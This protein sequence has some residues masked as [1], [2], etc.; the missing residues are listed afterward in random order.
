MYEIKPGVAREVDKMVNLRQPS[1]DKSYEGLVNELPMLEM[2]VQEEKAKMGKR[3]E[4]RSTISQSYQSLLGDQV[5][6]IYNNRNH[7]G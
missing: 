2:K 3:G 1:F 6:A 7:P 5:R 4:P